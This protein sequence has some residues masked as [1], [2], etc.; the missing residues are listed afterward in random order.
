MVCLRQ[1]SVLV[2]LCGSL[3]LAGEAP[4]PVT[5][6]KPP[7]PV[8]PPPVNP[9]Q[10]GQ[11]VKADPPKDE[12]KP[13]QPKYPPMDF[14]KVL[15]DLASTDAATRLAGVKAL[16]DALQEPAK[17][18]NLKFIVRLTEMSS[19]E[20]PIKKDSALKTIDN[21]L[22]QF[23]KRGDEKQLA[24]WTAKVNA[25]DVTL[26]DT[27]AAYVDGFA[28]GEEIEKYIQQLASADPAVVGEATKKLKEFGADAAEYLVS[29]LEDEHATI[30]KNAAEVLKELGPV[31]KDVG[32]DLVWLLESDDKAARKLAATVL[33][34][35]APHADPDLADDLMRY[36]DDEDKATRRLA[37]NILKKMGPK[38][39]EATVD[40]VD[41]LTDDDR[42][43]RSHA[44]EVLI[45]LGPHAKSGVDALVEIID[46]AD[47][48]ADSRIRAA[49]VLAAIG[50]EAKGAVET[51]TKHQKD[52]SAEVK[53]AVDAAIA[54]IG[55]K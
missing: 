30:K 8:D 1:V 7:V 27:L 43:V 16:L 29:A 55:T 13:E 23:K 17:K 6:P 21:A 47:N 39:A 49:N 3:C 10:P 9:A 25:G 51:L 5:P 11:P 4:D 48:D 34:G 35:I 14:G 28:K 36:I 2:L 31:A 33:E 38:A 18:Q 37:S 52:P 19:G 44:V 41:F 12:P 45:A 46:D 54:K 15:K 24:D 53:A 50:P 42:N 26:R 22:T 20:D 40:L 32:S